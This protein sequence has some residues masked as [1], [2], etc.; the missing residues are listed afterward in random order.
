LVK[1]ILNI[2][3]KPESLISFVE[4][5]LGHDIC[6]KLNSAKTRSIINLPK[7]DEQ[8]FLQYLKQTVES[9]ILP[10][11]KGKGEIPW[12]CSTISK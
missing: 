3:N 10:L 12:E 6:Y 11:N 5:R 1:N 2:L 7:Y 8:R 9:Y 4:D